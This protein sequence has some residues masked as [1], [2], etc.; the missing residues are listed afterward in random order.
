M[1]TQVVITPF[2]T[3][4]R[5]SWA[6]SREDGFSIWVS[7]GG[8]PASSWCGPL[9][10]S[11]PEGLLLCSPR[12]WQV[13]LK[14]DCLSLWLASLVSWNTCF[15]SSPFRERVWEQGQPPV[16]AHWSNMEVFKR[17]CIGQGS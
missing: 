2:G 13:G 3:G 4:I 15:L 17:A 10:G 1:T 6:C 14:D 12:Q 8:D 9:C 7:G 16:T 11:W 5:K